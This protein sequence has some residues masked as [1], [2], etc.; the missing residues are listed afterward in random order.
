VKRTLFALTIVATLAGC[1]I[2][3]IGP[4]GVTVTRPVYVNARDV[5]VYLKL[6][7]VP[8]HYTVIEDI[9]V[10]DDGAT[11][12]DALVYKLRVMAGGLGANA[13]VLDSLNRD[14]HRSSVAVGIS[15]DDKPVAR[16]AAIWIGEGSPPVRQLR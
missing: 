2:E 15:L 5:Q 7:D 16:A 6:K 10:D 14:D 11:P 3:S 1:R 9:A 13:I 12:S 4:Q 8:G